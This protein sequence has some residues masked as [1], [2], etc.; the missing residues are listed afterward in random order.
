LPRP[1]PGADRAARVPVEMVASDYLDAL[2]MGDAPSIDEFIS[3]T[4]EHAE[5]LRD[6]LPLVAA[7]E[8]WKADKH[9]D[10]APRRLPET[11]NIHRLGDCRILREIGR[12]GMGIVFEGIQ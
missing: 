3:R 11:F 6:L 12:G 2:R 9:L 5:E 8:E 1:A 4:P 10:A 7:M